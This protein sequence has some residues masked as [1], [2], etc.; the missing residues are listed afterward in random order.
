MKRVTS[1]TRCR[2]VCFSVLAIVM[3]M[4][5]SACTGRGGGWLP[6][7]DVVFTDKASFGF[8]VK[9]ERSS[10]AF[11]PNPKAARLHIE[12]S[13]TEHGTYVGLDDLPVGGP[14]SIHGVVD[15][16]DPVD[17]SMLCTGE[18]PTADENR[19]VFLGRFRVASAGP[20]QFAG[21]RTDT[22]QCRFEVIV[23]DN[24]RSGMPSRGDDFAI[25]LSGTTVAATILYGPPLYARAG[26]LAG[27]NLTVD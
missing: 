15:R 16:I 18:N 26:E 21:C 4:L 14:F 3:V 25:T 19:L 5:L 22:P 20:G 10:N 6:P 1:R 7:D 11:N 12:L 2:P 8:S 23:Q 9:C 24:D 27:G 17:E 13:Y